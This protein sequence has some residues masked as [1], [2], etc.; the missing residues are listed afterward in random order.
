MIEM[1]WAVVIL[2]FAVHLWPMAAFRDAFAEHRHEG[3][4]IEA[5]SAESAEKETKKA[6]EATG[7][8][9][10]FLGFG[11]VPLDEVETQL[12]QVESQESNL[13]SGFLEL[14]EMQLHAKQQGRSTSS[15][16]KDY[17]LADPDACKKHMDALH[18]AVAAFCKKVQPGLQN[19]S[20]GWLTAVTNVS[21]TKMTEKIIHALQWGKRDE[22][23]GLLF[24]K[25]AFTEENSTLLLW[26]GVSPSSRA[27]WCESLN[28]YMLHAGENNDI[29]TPFGEI[30]ESEGIKNET[31][32]NGHLFGSC[33]W[34]Q[35]EP[36]WQSASDAVV[37]RNGDNL[38]YFAVNKP[39]VKSPESEWTLE[40]TVFW[41]AEL[42]TLARYPP[43]EGFRVLNEH[44]HVRCCHLM[45]LIRSRIE[46][47]GLLSDWQKVDSFSCIDVGQVSHPYDRQ[48]LKDHKT[49][50]LKPGEPL[51]EECHVDR[52]LTQKLYEDC[53]AHGKIDFKFFENVARQFPPDYLPHINKLRLPQLFNKHGEPLVMMI[54]DI[55]EMFD[56]SIVLEICLVQFTKDNHFSK[57]RTLCGHIGQAAAKTVPK[58]TKAL[59]DSYVHKEFRKSA[60]EALGAIGKETP[61][62]SK[63]FIQELGSALKDPDKE[64]RQAA[65]GALGAIGQEVPKQVVPQLK[66]ALKFDSSR[67][68][69]A[70]AL[71]AIGREIPDES[72]EV[73]RHFRRDL[74]HPKEKVRQA[75]AGVLGAIG[76]EVPEQVLQQL[77]EALRIASSREAAAVALGVMGPAAEAA[78]PQ[79]TEELRDSHHE[80]LRKFAA[81]ALGAIGKESPKLSE[82]CIQE[83]GSALKDPDENVRQAAAG[84]LGAI[85]QEAPWQVLPQ[86][87]EAL[88]FRGRWV[89]RKAGAVGLRAMG[90]AAQEAERELQEALRDGKWEVRHAAAL[91]IE[92][93]FG[94]EAATVFVDAGFKGDRYIEDIAPFYLSDPGKHCGK[95]KTPTDW[96][97]CQKAAEAISY[98]KRRQKSSREIPTGGGGKC[99]EQGWG[100]VPIGCSVK[101][102]DD[103]AT[104]FKPWGSNCVGRDYQMV[105]RLGWDANI[106]LA[107]KGR[108]VCPGGSNSPRNE[109]ECKAAAAFIYAKEKKNSDRD[110]QVGHGGDCSGGWG[111]VPRGCSVQ[112][113]G[114]WAAHLKKSNHRCKTS[115]LYQLVCIEKW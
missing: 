95:G 111:V 68:A 113:G 43:A 71:G 50:F 12:N 101:S 86:L 91:A 47:N 46:Q 44:H 107:K 103:W 18:S 66:E 73:I 3:L 36:I 112:S 45:P 58:L 15:T 4:H 92:V 110:L 52:T 21:V 76:Q 7:K 69:A 94:E 70:L 37:W 8:T 6:I 24:T 57:L 65:A 106:Y 35:Q 93:A 88:K 74:E 26:S 96:M 90:A 53:R 5:K 23:H 75:A 56:T 48:N 34:S 61:E 27:K 41:K 102:G 25:K 104:H 31:G 60:A 109:D 97:S 13:A 40:N 20:Y 67:E 33:N 10:G 80:D 62:L 105:C 42:P 108:S 83:L 55:L 17:G 28:M 82:Q 89:V 99:S 49:E 98:L 14:H 59:G 64:V 51:S 85:G 2:L 114:D 30:L 63:Q 9:T 81:E 115:F 100:A 72:K 84:A 39:L 29:Q 32:P 1:K 16:R 77:I 79:L 78:V 19:G 11:K 38:V 87:I 54:P 22:S